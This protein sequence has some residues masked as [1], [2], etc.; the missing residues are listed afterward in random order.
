M[1]DLN[2][3]SIFSVD[4]AQGTGQMGE[5]VEIGFFDHLRNVREIFFHEANEL[6]FGHLR[7][8]DAGIAVIDLL[9]GNAVD[10][11]EDDVE[12]TEV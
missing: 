4:I 8:V 2:I 6:F 11:A 1:T 10:G 9:E 7:K 5:N 3:S 12:F